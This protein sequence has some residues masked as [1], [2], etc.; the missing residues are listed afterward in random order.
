M[1]ILTEREI[2]Q[3]FDSYCKTVLRNKAND[4]LKKEK[5]DREHLI[6]LEYLLERHF[7]ENQLFS[8]PDETVETNIIPL[9]TVNVSISL[10]DD[11]LAE[12]LWLLKEENREILLLYYFLSMKDEEIGKKFSKSRKT[13]QERRNRAI[14]K[15]RSVLT[16]GQQHE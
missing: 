14:S 12:A 15:L 13:I 11:A 7:T 8:T 9:A 10:D 4:I 16:K 3:R 5:Q 6:S 2:E 1:T